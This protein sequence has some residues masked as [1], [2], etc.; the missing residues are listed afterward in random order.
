MRHPTTD[1]I[2]SIPIFDEVDGRDFQWIEK[3]AYVQNLPKGTPL[4]K[5]GTPGDAMFFIS[6]GEIDI[7]KEAEGG[8]QVHLA[9]LYKGA[10]LG[11]MSLVDSAPRS[12]S[13]VAKTD[14]KL[15]YLKKDSFK[16]FL[17]EHPRPACKIL[18]KLLRTLSLRLR[19]ADSKV[20]D[21]SS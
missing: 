4:F 8:K 9:T 1:E 2:S 21:G 17:D 11:E 13:A 18:L 15:I 7:I 5:E 12:A 16:I 3:T 6:S 19:Q 14:V 10:V 20:V